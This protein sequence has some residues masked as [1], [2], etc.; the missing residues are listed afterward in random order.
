M[1]KSLRL[2]RLF[3]F[4]TRRTFII[5]MDH[6]T[7]LG[8]IEGIN[9][10]MK[11][12]KIIDTSEA[13]AVVLHKGSIKKMIQ[14]DKS[15]RQGIIMHMSASTNLI[16][17]DM[18]AQVADV[19]EAIRMGCDGVSVHLNLLEHSPM[20]VLSDLG[21][22]SSKCDEWGMPL[23]VMV[24]GQNPSDYHETIRLL[25]VVQELGADIIKISYSGQ[26]ESLKGYIDALHV[27]VVLSGGEIEPS[28]EVTTHRVF[29]ALENGFSGV[30]FGRNI[31][32]DGSIALKSYI[33]SKAIHQN[34]SEEE[35]R[36]YY[37]EH[38][39]CGKRYI[40]ASL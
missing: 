14:L 15:V 11:T 10:Y 28:F 16:K 22:I 35:C 19:E 33:L 32:S 9:D 37:R 13:N 8:P 29:M 17:G 38:N 3:N 1:N 27:P 40:V 12:L 7:T 34:W 31:F 25:K 23:L 24:Y 6:G 18:K 20:N 39:D 21:R 4:S 36:E 26:F 30:A 2:S 5:P